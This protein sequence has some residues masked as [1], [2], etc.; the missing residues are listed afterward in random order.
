MASL[1]SSLSCTV[2]RLNLF[3][4]LSLNYHSIRIYRTLSSNLR[5][6][7]SLY[8]HRSF[9]SPF[10]SYTCK[11]TISNCSKTLGSNTVFYDN[12]VVL[13]IETSCDDTAAAVVSKTLLKPTRADLW[14]RIPNLRRISSFFVWCWFQV[15]SNG[16]ILSQVVS[17]Q[18]KR[19]MDNNKLFHIAYFLLGF[20]S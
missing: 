18:V 8:H 12:L 2:S 11:S 19:F 6:M 20:T 10:S 4:E 15:R 14:H 7:K 5:P 13:G 16:E 3:A 17:S 9:N 1:A